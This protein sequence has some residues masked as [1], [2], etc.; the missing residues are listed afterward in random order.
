MHASR[1]QHHPNVNV[2]WT[3]FPR[4]LLRDLA[5]RFKVM[6]RGL[7]VGHLF[8]IVVEILFHIARDR[9]LFQAS[10]RTIS[11][12]FPPSFRHFHFSLVTPPPPKCAPCKT[13]KVQFAQ[14]SCFCPNFLG[15]VH[16]VSEWRDKA[17][18][19]LFTKS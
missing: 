18:R 1:K 9:D 13:L 4:I 11:E 5:F 14:K 10:P 17:G 3:R 19:H 8:T 12:Y 6:M 2:Q 16:R 7:G 15:Q